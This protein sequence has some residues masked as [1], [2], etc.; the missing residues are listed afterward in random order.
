MT[1]RSLVIF[2]IIMVA[3]IALG[4]FL[5]EWAIFHITRSLGLGLVVLGLML[6]LR[7]GLVSFGQALY[8]CLGAY[9]A[10]ILMHFYKL[11]EAFLLLG[12]GTLAAALLA[13]LL[14]ALM[15]N[16]RGIFFGLLSLAFS[17]ILYGVI[18]KSAGLGSTDGFTLT[19]PTFFGMALGES[20]RYALFIIACVI[21]LVSVWGLQRYL[22]TPLGSLAPAIRDNE[23]R[24]E[25][26]GQS[27]R[28]AIHIKYVISA[29]LAG[30]GGALTALTVGHIDPEMA[31]WT[32]S[33][34]FVFILILS[35]SLSVIAPFLGALLFESL[36]TYAYQEFPYVWQMVLGVAMLLVISFLPDGI[37]SLFRS[38]KTKPA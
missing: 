24:V 35:G 37:W 25:Y 19:S 15:A 20:S 32:T 3:L 1:S 7:A 33:G 9:T 22:H 8:Y 18:V 12:A 14:G 36:R 21:T 2:S 28:N 10:G 11:H 29:A 23:I 13:A 26:L 6:M 34:E 30:L 38:R 16:Y 31:Y 4:G 5:P 27:V 17:M